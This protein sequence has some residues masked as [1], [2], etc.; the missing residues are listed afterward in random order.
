MK[1]IKEQ[2]YRLIE[3]EAESMDYEEAHAYAHRLIKQ[4]YYADMVTGFKRDDEETPV[5]FITV[6]KRYHFCTNKKTLP[7][8]RGRVFFYLTVSTIF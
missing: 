6:K 5:Y 7:P 8:Y 2:Q 4:R 3:I 1:I